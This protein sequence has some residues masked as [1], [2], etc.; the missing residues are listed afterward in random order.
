MSSLRTTV[1]AAAFAITCSLVPLFGAAPASAQGASVETATD[2]Q[3]KTAEDSFKKGMAA[4][5]KGKHEEALAAFRASYDA[6]ASPNSHLMVARTLVKLGRFAEAWNEYEK[7]QA[8]A[9][10]AGD[11]KYEQTA[12]AARTEG[13]EV[14]SKIALITV[15]V[16]GAPEGSRVKLGGQDLESSDWGKPIAVM[17]GAVRVELTLVTGEETSREVNAQAGGEETV[18]LT[19]PATGGP[20]GGEEGDSGAV[21]ARLDENTSL[22]TW[23]YVAGGVGIAG[24]VTFGVFGAMNNSKFSKLEDECVDK[25]CSKDLEEDADSGKTY[26]TI[27]NVGLA[28][29]VVGLAAGTVLFLASSSEERSAR[30]KRSPAARPRVD[31][32]VGPRWVGV[33]GQF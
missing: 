4:A 20:P 14:R 29:G 6:V 18:T 9:Q 21:E 26:Q 8:E 12:Q 1:R 10:A 28:V 30:A 24:L 16:P 32:N 2:E 25:R 15:E 27:A 3:K 7:T 33:N 17:P 31:L 11:P 22:R 19:P 23:A 13:S 5:N